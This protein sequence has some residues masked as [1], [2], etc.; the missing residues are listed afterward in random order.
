M[1]RLNQLKRYRKHLEERYNKLVERANDYKYVDEGKS[2]RSAFKAM[3]VLE[4]LN[5]V[6]YLD[7]EI[8]KAIS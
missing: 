3:K 2:D 5:R 6:K 1:S 4:K 7:Q 8:S